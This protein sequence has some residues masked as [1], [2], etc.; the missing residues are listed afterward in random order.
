MAL[1][2]GDVDTLRCGYLGELNLGGI[3]SGKR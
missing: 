2:L 1:D 3:G